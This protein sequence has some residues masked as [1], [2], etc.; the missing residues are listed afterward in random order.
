[1]SG[2]LYAI[3]PSEIPQG[4][5][6]QWVRAAVFNRPD[7]ERLAEAKSFGW[8]DVPWD[9]HQRKYARYR[10]DAGGIEVCGLRLME[11]PAEI[12]AAVADE[13]DASHKIL[14]ELGC[15]RQHEVHDNSAVEQVRC[16]LRDEVLRHR[17]RDLVRDLCWILCKSVEVSPTRKVMVRQPK[18]YS[19]DLAVLPFYGMDEWL[20]VLAWRLFEPK[21][22]D[23]VTGL[24][25]E[26]PLPEGPPTEDFAAAARAA[27]ADMVQR[28]SR[29]IA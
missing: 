8:V 27:A 9:R 21:A 28:K 2:D 3:E 6:Y 10:T 11:R 7:D 29:R 16:L 24:L 13:S 23:I 17:F 19:S 15:L 14:T 12:T 22:L 5:S 20:T 18:R 25:R 1:M 26:R 4:T